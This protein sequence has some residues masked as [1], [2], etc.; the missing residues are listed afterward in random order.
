[1]F[2]VY[3]APDDSLMNCKNKGERIAGWWEFSVANERVSVS[4][5]IDPCKRFSLRRERD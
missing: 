2:I 4:N 1:M 3:E 5:S